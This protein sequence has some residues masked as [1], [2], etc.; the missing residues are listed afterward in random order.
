MFLDLFI[1][2]VSNF[3]AAKSTNYDVNNSGENTR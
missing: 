1:D 2:F 3:S